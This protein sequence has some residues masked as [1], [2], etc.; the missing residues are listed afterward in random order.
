MGPRSGN[1]DQAWVGRESLFR[2]KLNQL[3]TN[4][5]ITTNT[6]VDTNTLNRI[7]EIERNTILDNLH[8]N[9]GKID[10]PDGER[11]ALLDNLTLLYNNQTIM[12]ILSDELKRAKRY[13]Y[14]S[15]LVMMTVDGI[16]DIAI[17]YSPL[18]ADSI[19]QGAATFLMKTIRDVDI[20]SRY[21][22]E[23]FM[24]ICP[25]TDSTGAKVLA[26]RIRN[27]ICQDRISDIGQNWTVTA[28][29]GVVEFPSQGTTEED[30]IR[31]AYTAM[32]NTR[33]QGG[34]GV[35]VVEGAV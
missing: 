27:K 11:I 6:P 14:S 13:R 20:P 19:M 9:M 35:G 3:R 4:G 15:T 24:I 26:E 33:E 31:L 10:Q 7:K 1:N 12:R 22:S 29:V 28:S 18:A 17:K 25:N 2:R 30:L 34:N 21:D 23:T 8:S 16:A 32:V 5:N